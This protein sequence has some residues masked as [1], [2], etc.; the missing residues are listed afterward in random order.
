[1]RRNAVTSIARASGCV[2]RSLK[3]VSVIMSGVEASV[4]ELK[5]THVERVSST[6]LVSLGWQSNPGE[7]YRIETSTD[8]VTWTRAK[9]PENN[10]VPDLLPQGMFSTAEVN[11]EVSGETRRF[12]RVRALHPWEE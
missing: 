7:I 8:L 3:A 2:F 11:E 5:I 9:D 4:P 12:W 10:D 6:G 1:M